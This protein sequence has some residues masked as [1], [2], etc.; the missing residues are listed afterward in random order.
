MGFSDEVRK[1]LKDIER[2]AVRAYEITQQLLSFARKKNHHV[3]VFDVNRVVADSKLMLQ[4]LIGTQITLKTQLA[5]DQAFVRADQSEVEQALMNLV[6]NARDA[7]P[8]GGELIIRTG[9]ERLEKDRV[10]Q[11]CKAGR[12]VQL[13]VADEGCGMSPEIVERIFEPFF[14]T[15]LVGEGTGLGLS[16]VYSDIANSDGFVSVES[17]EGTGTVI[18]IY[19]PIS[20]QPTIEVIAEKESPSTAESRGGETILVCDDEEIVLSSVTALLQSVGYSVIAAN[21]AKEALAAA[22]ANAEKIAL[23]VTDLT[24][25]EMNGVELGKEIHRR[26]PHM[27]II[28]SS[29]YAADHVGICA[30]DD[31]VEI[32]E[33]GRSSDEM[34]RR[35]RAVL[36]RDGPS[37]R[38]NSS[39]AC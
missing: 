6:I 36:D 3:T 15:K 20:Q 28:Y 4:R 17:H 13:S 35:I 27:K 12:F 21:S 19:L 22:D 39:K 30:Q 26:H 31:G 16:T 11:H 7:M 8:H 32:L 37:D 1:P 29:G 5:D 34:F 10:P 23:M 9:I 2:S 25:P 33:K 14:T 18:N 38:E 24:M